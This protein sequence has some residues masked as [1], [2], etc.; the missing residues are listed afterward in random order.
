MSSRPK[1]P[2]GASESRA[3]RVDQ[4]SAVVWLLV[5]AAIVNESRK[6]DY[7]A[8][9]GFGPGFLPFWIGVATVILALILLGQSTLNRAEVGLEFPT[10]H[11]ARQISIVVASLFVF[12]LLA[13]KVGFMI[14][15]ALLFMFLLVV[16]ER[17]G[18][19]ISLV[20]TAAST[21]TF[22]A[23]FVGALH[24]QLPAGLLSLFS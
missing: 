24:V 22:W 14:C 7:E 15:V 17:K 20:I 19:R 2:P 4:V 12:A 13:E 10:G 23:I 11:A 1:E 18:W 5:G 3:R 21:F 8:E 16:V 6:L 9:F